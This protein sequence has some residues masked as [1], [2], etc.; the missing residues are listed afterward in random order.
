[1][2]WKRCSV[3]LWSTLGKPPRSL[4]FFWGPSIACCM[5]DCHYDSTGTE[6]DTH[7][8]ISLGSTDRYLAA[9]VQN[10]PH[11]A[12]SILGGAEPFQCTP[13]KIE[14]LELYTFGHKN[15]RSSTNTIQKHQQLSNIGDLRKIALI[16]FNVTNLHSTMIATWDHA[17]QDPE[18]PK[19]SQINN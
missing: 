17:N 9:N 12:C 19:I 2:Q 16:A 8:A 18:H 13:I 4:A 6:M 5:H 11:D 10:S 1:M 14:L 15:L 3:N 7:H